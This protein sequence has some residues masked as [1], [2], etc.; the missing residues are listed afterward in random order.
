MRELYNSL[1]NRAHF[2]NGGIILLT[3]EYLFNIIFYLIKRLHDF[4]LSIKRRQSIIKGMT[5]SLSI[6]FFVTHQLHLSGN[7]IFYTASGNILIT[8]SS[9]ICH[10]IL[11]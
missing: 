2:I 11:M 1:Q 8:L 3:S 10:P 7:I 6:N 9:N 5:F 4:I